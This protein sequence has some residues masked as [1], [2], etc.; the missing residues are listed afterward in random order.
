MSASTTNNSNTTNTQAKSN[1]IL[2]RN[3]SSDRLPS[4]PKESSSTPTPRASL[5]ILSKPNLDLNNNNPNNISLQTID[6]INEEQTGRSSLSQ[7]NSV[8]QTN[9]S[10]L[11]I[12][13]SHGNNSNNNNNK[14]TK[15]GNLLSSLKNK[16]LSASSRL[17]KS[18]PASP[19]PSSLHNIVDLETCIITN[20][21]NSVIQEA[22]STDEEED[23]MRRGNNKL[24]F[25]S[26]TSRHRTL[27]DKSDTYL[28][29]G[30]DDDHESEGDSD[31]DLDTDYETN[32]NLHPNNNHHPNVVVNS[33]LFDEDD[34]DED[35]T[36]NVVD[37]V[38]TV[39]DNLSS[40]HKDL[41]EGFFY[42]NQTNSNNNNND[43]KSIGLNNMVS[44]N[45]LKNM[46]NKI[47]TTTTTIPTT[48]TTTAAA[49]TFNLECKLYIL[50]LFVLSSSYFLYIEQRIYRNDV[51][52]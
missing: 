21:K 19:A 34:D 18:R 13:S 51:I 35:R 40:M 28:N 24:S 49:T 37:H 12:A 47:T 14:K 29:D 45:S 4:N 50:Y 5:S 44:R 16:T 2:L 20:D 41:D 1:V 52:N 38:E 43:N 15:A 22:N 6:V 8:K 46:F 30:D 17:L 7:I 33:S 23:E 36:I 9:T 27:T 25:F 48:T 39:D 26:S 10:N 32:S 3:I 42:K 31:S 11:S